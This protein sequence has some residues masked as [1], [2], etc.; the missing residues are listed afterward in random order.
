MRTQTENSWDI[1]EAR[2]WFWNSQSGLFHQVST[3]EG[4]PVQTVMT[5]SLENFFK[6]L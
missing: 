1:K 3:A 2:C 6:H 4:V 5:Y